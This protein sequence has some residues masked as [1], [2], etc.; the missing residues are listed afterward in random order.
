MIYLDSN[1]TTRVHPE[2]L[3]A[4]APFFTS[5]FGNP[6]SHHTVGEAAADA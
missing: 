6:S 1:A 2:V 3:E 5:R 4:M